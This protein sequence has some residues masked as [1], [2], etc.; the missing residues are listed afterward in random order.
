VAYDY[1]ATHAVVIE[2][3]DDQRFTVKFESVDTKA[4]LAA[5]ATHKSAFHV[6]N[7]FAHRVRTTGYR[8]QSINGAVVRHY[9]AH[10]IKEILVYGESEEI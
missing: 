10:R 5:P 4:V 1:E 7:D 9:P 8:H 2:L 6:A 3:D